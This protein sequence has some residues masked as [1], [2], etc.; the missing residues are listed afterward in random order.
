MLSIVMTDLRNFTA[1]GESFGDDVEGL[2]AIMNNY[3]TALSVPV[4]KN[5]GTLI[6]FIGDASL[7]VHGAPLDDVNH[8]KTAVNS[9]LN[10]LT[11]SIISRA[12]RTAVLA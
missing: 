11:A 9:S 10:T 7:H 12:V 1:L 2:T 3:M 4:L 8:A 6:K 5:N